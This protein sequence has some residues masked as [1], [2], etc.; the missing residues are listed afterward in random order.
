MWRE[1]WKLI[2]IFSHCLLFCI[3]IAAQNNDCVTAQII[4]SDGAVRFTPSSIGIDDFSN[5]NNSF[6]CFELALPLDSTA[7]NGSGWYY[8]EFRL[9]MPPNSVIEFTITPFGGYGEDYDF[10]VFGPNLSCD[11]LGEPVRCSFAPYVCDFCPAT[12]LGMG[13]TDNSEGVWFDANNLIYSDGFVA[14]MVVQPGDG[15]YLLLD[16][17][18]RT[19]RGFTLTWGGSAAPFLNCIV[20]PL[21]RNKTVTAGDDMEVCAGV[22]PFQ[23]NG[24]AENVSSNVIYTWIGDPETLSFLSDIHDPQAIVTIPDTYSGTI[25]YILTI[26]DGQCGLADDMFIT[27]NPNAPPRISGDTIICVGESTTIDAGPGYQ[28]YLWSNGDTTQ[29]MVTNAPNTYSVTVTTFDGCTNSN[30]ITITQSNNPQ[31]SI[32][33]GNIICIGDPITIDAGANFSSYLWSTGARTR[34]IDVTTQGQYSVTVTNSNGCEGMASA[35]ITEATKPTPT[36]QGDSVFCFNQSTRLR[37]TQSFPR[38]IW[39]TNATTNEITVA[40]TGNYAVTV[41][42]I[43]GCTGTDTLPVREKEQL[44]VNIDGDLSIC[45]EETTTLSATPGFETYQWSN[46]NNDPII[47]V[48]I[49]GNY[50]VTVTDINNCEGIDSV[51]V[52][53][54]PSPQLN[55]Y[56]ASGICP[57]TSIRIETDSIFATY[58]W[59]N[60]DITSFTNINNPGIYTL[61]VTNAEGCSSDTS[62]TLSL[63]PETKPEIIGDIKFCPDIGGTLETTEPFMSYQ[64]SNDSITAVTRVFSDGTYFVTV[65]DVNGCLGTDSITVDAYTVETPPVSRDTNLCTGNTIIL[66]ANV[67]FEHYTWSTGDTTRSITVSE[68]AI[69][70]LTVSDIN[71]CSATATYTVREDALPDVPIMGSDRICIGDTR[72]LSVSSDFISVLWS[73]NMTTPTI[74]INAPDTFSVTVTDANGCINSNSIIITGFEKPDPNIIAPNAICDGEEATLRLSESYAEYRW[75]TGSNLPEILINQGTIYSVEVTDING[76]TGMDS[77]PVLERSAPNAQI[78]GDTF[79]CQGLQ[80]KLKVVLEPG[81]FD[82]RW[83]TGEQV[84]SITVDR[85]GAYSVFVEDEFG[86]TVTK[87]VNVLQRALP[88]AN[89]GTAARLNCQDTA[90]QLGD[91]GNNGDVDYEWNGPGINDSNRHLSNP[92][93]SQSGTYTLIVTDKIYGCISEPPDVEVL[94]DSYTPTAVAEAQGILDCQTNSVVLDASKSQNGMNIIYRWFDAQNQIIASNNTPV[95]TV[96]STGIFYLE[97]Q[98]TRLGCVGKDTI[99][100]SA[101]YDLPSVNAGEDQ[102][103]TCV[104]NEA[105]LDGSRSATGAGFSYLWATLDGNILA[106]ATSSQPT[107]NRIGTYILTVQNGNNGC[108]NSDTVLVLANRDAPLAEAGETQFLD[109]NIPEATLDATNSSGGNLIYQWSSNDGNQISNPNLPI[110]NVNKPGIYTLKVTNIDNGCAA[111]DLVEVIDDTNYPTGI[112]AKLFDPLCENDKNGQIQIAQTFGGTPPFV[113]SLNGRPFEMVNGFSGLGAGNYR[114]A[115]EDA[116]GCRYETKFTLD[117][118]MRLRVDLGADIILNQPEESA[119][120]EPIVNV[121]RR[122]ITGMRWETGNELFDSCVCW[123]QRVSPTETTLY[124]V[125]VRNDLGCEATD[126][127]LVT[128]TNDIPIFIPNAFS[129]NGDGYNDIFMIYSG[130]TPFKM[131]FLYLYQRWGDQVF[132]AVDLFTNDESRGWDGTF[133]GKKLNPGVYVYFFEIELANGDVIPF[134][135]DVTLVR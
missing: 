89:A 2:A 121:P 11:S 20:D 95:L 108:I 40:A 32:T 31:T 73:N 102:S 122:E 39:S 18:A 30:S 7:E 67:D 37:T 75:S 27:V 49:P 90:V 14:P 33:G 28:R 9:D 19:T 63:F 60:G 86:C 105:I 120:L 135:G 113:Y 114:L 132:T 8:F 125:T 57:G 71:S 127:L 82:I 111:Q 130:S 77:V 70:T 1:S 51:T 78:I 43:N 65:T 24:S 5:P 110:I 25:N 103:L 66:D 93:I 16:N 58:N 45:A 74:Q 41:T 80:A 97:V 35:N 62:I 117:D 85:Q 3:N 21:C 118:G 76:C 100:V 84:D 48:N 68:G 23:L 88:T 106:N 133:K 47:N 112:E 61:R 36:I 59:S 69:Y 107:V 96:N 83:S 79:F 26:N 15:Y 116:A 109:C 104:K 99:E 81:D 92:I 115:V 131:R 29:S 44:N 22:P 94:D 38:Y 126:D 17:F 46:S 124:R 129:P 101:N 119:V 128:L 10:M 55:I 12:G 98:D 91:P 72:A 123:Q 134:K 53:E 52:I 50:Y 87:I 6:G 42:D 64:W 54:N 13:A 4:C 56:G 34:T